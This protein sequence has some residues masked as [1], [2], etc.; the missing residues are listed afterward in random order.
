MGKHLKYRQRVQI[1]TL[2]KEGCTQSYIAE[3]TGV[4]QSAISREISRNT[5]GKEIYLADRAHE[6]ALLRAFN[7]RRKAPLKKYE[8]W[9]YVRWSLEK[10]KWTPEAI[11]RRLRNVEKR[12]SVSPQAI[13]QWLHRLPKSQSALLTKH[14]PYFNK[15]RRG[16]YRNGSKFL[17]P[18]EYRR[19][20]HRPE[21]VEKREEIGHLETDNMGGKKGDK[22]SVSVTVERSSR[23]VFAGKLNDLKAKTKTKHLTNALKSQ[24]VL[25]IT[26]DNGSENAGYKELEQKLE[27]EYYF[28][29][30]YHSWEKGT[31]ENVIG[32][33]RRYIPK[34]TSLDELSRQKLASVAK[35]YNQ[36]PKK[37][38]N[39]LTPEEVFVHNLS[40]QDYAFP[41]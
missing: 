31:V 30:P 39:W 33:L 27:A 5:E 28:C 4:S 40:P 7:Q 2:L 22:T 6:R 25:S 41:G 21:V 16:K 20:D 32:W 15:R 18:E 38:L 10:K 19:I 11:S 34:G 14:L 1:E 24:K 26:A 37:C 3:Q 12:E 17:S 13:Y 23:Y 8:I 35:R 9:E 36:T 29:N